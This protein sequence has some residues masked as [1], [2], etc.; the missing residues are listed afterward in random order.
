MSESPPVIP[1][2]RGPGISTAKDPYVRRDREN[3]NGARGRKGRETPH[4]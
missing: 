2:E 1:V 3:G 4:C